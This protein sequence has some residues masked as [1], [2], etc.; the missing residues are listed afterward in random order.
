M[1]FAKPILAGLAV[2]A[3]AVGVA[4]GGGGGTAPAG[5]PKPLAK[6]PNRLLFMLN[7]QQFVTIDPDGK[8]G[9][10]LGEKI[11]PNITSEARLSPDGKKY[12]VMIRSG[13][14]EADDSYKR[15]N[16]VVRGIEPGVKETDLGTYG[17]L[18][19]WHG[20]CADVVVWSPDGTELAVNDCYEAEGKEVGAAHFL[21]NVATKAKTPIKLSPDHLITDWSADG[22]HFLTTS[23]DA[24]GEECVWGIHLMNR[25]GT[26][27]KCVSGAAQSYAF[28][29][30][31][32]DGKRVLFLVA[33]RPRKIVND[34]WRVLM[35][36]DIETGNTSVVAGIPEDS[37]VWGH[38]WSPDGTR[39]AFVWAEHCFASNGDDR[40]IE[41]RLVVCD[42]DGKNATIVASEKG[43]LFGAVP[44]TGL[45][46]R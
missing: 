34:P 19:S 10:K 44:I 28:G 38:C 30:L 33:P 25:D 27:H 3:I 29:R 43:R 37:R 4:F 20:R 21:L 1:L 16:I 2:S 12:A 39:V 17:S 31:S 36:M 14:A 24:K 26:E 13:Q 18:T 11:W 35:V 9:T 15:R 45:D 41:S 8:N 23:I 7:H 40:D 6:G 22:K 42:L 46:W 5:E 32:P